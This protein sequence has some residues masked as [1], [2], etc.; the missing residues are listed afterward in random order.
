MNSQFYLTGGDQGDYYTN[1]TEA[2]IKT[3]DGT[4]L[5]PIIAIIPLDGAVITSMKDKDGVAIVANFITEEVAAPSGLAAMPLNNLAI[6]I[7]F[8]GTIQVFYK[9]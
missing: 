2:T 9:K 6:E 8:T 1:A 7:T 5:Y 4:L 3:S